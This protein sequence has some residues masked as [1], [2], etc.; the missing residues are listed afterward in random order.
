MEMQ[1]VKNPPHCSRLLVLGLVFML[2][3]CFAT[4]SLLD[5]GVGGAPGYRFSGRLCGRDGCCFA[6]TPIVLTVSW[7]DLEGSS[8]VLDGIVTNDAGGFEERILPGLPTQ[9][10]RAGTH[11]SDC[12]DDFDLF[13]VAPSEVELSVT[14][15]EVTYDVVVIVIVDEDVLPDFDPHRGYEVNI[16]TIILAEVDACM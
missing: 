3:G 15:Q 10:L 7:D 2:C 13:S 5:A 12:A 16:G 11:R 4:D 8:V 6:N 9:R 1:V 14:V